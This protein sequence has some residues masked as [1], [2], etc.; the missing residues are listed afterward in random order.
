MWSSDF[1]CIARDNCSGVAADRLKDVFN[2]PRVG[3]AEGIRGAGDDRVIHYIMR[4]SIREQEEA[5]FLE[6]LLGADFADERARIHLLDRDIK[7]DVVR[8]PL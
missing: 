7:N 6:L 8:L 3:F 5:K 4:E 2:K 1:T